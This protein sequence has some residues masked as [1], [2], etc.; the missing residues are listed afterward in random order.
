MKEFL[1]FT[2]DVKLLKCI[3]RGLIFLTILSNREK[4]LLAFTKRGTNIHF[5]LVFGSETSGLPPEALNE[6]KNEPLG[7]GTLKIPKVETYVLGHICYHI[8]VAGLNG[9]MATVT[10]LKS[11]SNKW[12]CGAALITAMMT[13]KHYGRGSGSGSGATTLGKPFVHPATVDLRGKVYELFRQN[14]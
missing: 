1:V 5:W 8:L 13:V 3:A 12:R 4:R 7:G 14:E 9:Y 10:N 2:S 6:C 11:P